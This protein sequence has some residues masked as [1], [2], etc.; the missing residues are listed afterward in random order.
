MLGLR[1]KNAMRF[2]IALGSLLIAALPACGG[3]AV[4][5]QDP[6]QAPPAA[7]V[8]YIAAAHS[9]DGIA[10]LEQRCLAYPDLPGNTW[11]AG[12]AK[13]RCALLRKPMLTL[14]GIAS[15]LAAPDGAATLD[16]RYAQLLQAHYNDPSQREQIFVSYEVFD[17]TD[18][19][20]QVASR[21]LAASPN[22]AYATFALGRQLAEQGWKARGEKEANETPQT[23]L[24]AM[25]ANFALAAPL[26][27][28]AFTL[29]PRLSPAC[30]A[31]AAIG[32]MSSRTLHQRAI[33]KCI[34]VDPDAYH[35]AVERIYGAQPKWGGSA[36]ALRE[37]VAYA[38]A[39]LNKNPMLGALVAM[40]AGY[41]A[42]TADDLPGLV[43]AAK[44]A[45]D[46]RFLSMAGEDYA[47]QEDPWDGVAYLSQGLRFRPMQAGYRYRRAVELNRLGYHAWA[48]D[49]AQEA[50]RLDS[51]DGWHHYEVGRTVRDLEGEQAARPYY[52]RA[53]ADPDSRQ[54]AYVLY[55]QSFDV[56]HESSQALACTAAMTKEYPA[57]GEG[58]RLRANAL[59]A[60][61]D[62]GFYDAAARFFATMDP[63]QYPFQVQWA[64]RYR[65]FIAKVSKEQFVRTKAH[66]IVDP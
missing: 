61:G 43:A 17:S 65:T 16:G 42:D 2:W 28:Q 4:P 56:Q 57:D 40:G 52:Q 58:W 62:V 35:V 25:N 66:V 21:W 9:A 55:C 33:G 36:D 19:A 22:S 23:R 13:A 24:T 5:Q 34:E 48:L 38:A 60:A 32:R 39:R 44:L 20:H 63:V 6:P 37:A 41:D 45:P 7:W 18:Q 50:V 1:R 15:L 30:I 59:G 26:L 47:L 51:D 12:S 14:D 53:M 8:D 46:G 49:D 10:D 31:L 27:L 11:P 54:P 29:E 64:N 3:C